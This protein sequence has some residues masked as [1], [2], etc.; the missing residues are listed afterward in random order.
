VRILYHG[1]DKAPSDRWIQ[2]IHILVKTDLTL[3]ISALCL[4]EQ[5]KKEVRLARILKIFERAHP[6]RIA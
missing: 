6:S 5:I 4:E 3:S 2:P 1:K